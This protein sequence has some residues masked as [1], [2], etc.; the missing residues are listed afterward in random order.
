MLKNVGVAENL[1]K[2]LP[3]GVSIN[4]YSPNRIKNKGTIY[5][6]HG[7]Q[8]LILK[9]ISEQFPFFISLCENCGLLIRWRISRPVMTGLRTYVRRTVYNTTIEKVITQ[10]A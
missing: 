4:V 10:E 9:K 2:E 8:L 3:L 7:K 6:V 5:P 1:P